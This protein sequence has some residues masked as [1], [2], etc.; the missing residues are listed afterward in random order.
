MMNIAVFSSHGGSDLQAVIDGCW[1][2]TGWCIMKR[3]K[4]F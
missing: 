3:K 2:K 1:G 4:F